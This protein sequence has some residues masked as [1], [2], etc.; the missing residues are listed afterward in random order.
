ML[1]TKGK[2]VV[3]PIPFAGLVELDED[4]IPAS[5]DR[6][7]AIACSAHA[8]AVDKAGAPYILHPLRVMM[9]VPPEARIVA[10]L[11]DVIEDSD[12]SIADL[13]AEGFSPEDLISLEAVSRRPGESYSAFIDR[14][15]ADP[16][17]KIVKLADLRDNCDMSRFVSPSPADWERYDK[18]LSAI[19]YMELMD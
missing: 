9:A 4:F 18:Y 13:A 7:I 11:H 6:A 10:V 5:L 19:E 16:I 12:I 3:E 14:A 17:G 15:A 8:G 2:I 1:V